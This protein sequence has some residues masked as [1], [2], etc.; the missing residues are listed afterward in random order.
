MENKFFSLNMSFTIWKNSWN[1]ILVYSKPFKY[2]YLNAIP[3]P[4][5]S[6]NQ[7]VSIF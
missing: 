4:L 6:K 1:D 7:I 3:V 5:C 2:F